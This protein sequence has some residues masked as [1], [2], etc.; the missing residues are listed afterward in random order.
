MLTLSLSLCYSCWYT[1]YFVCIAILNRCFISVHL[2]SFCD[3]TSVGV[4][5][6]FFFSFSLHQRNRIS[7]IYC[8]KRWFYLQWLT[9]VHVSQRCNLHFMDSNKNEHIERMKLKEVE[10]ESA[11]H[12]EAFEMKF[13]WQCMT[14]TVWLVVKLHD[15]EI[16]FRAQL[17]IVP[18]FRFHWFHAVFS[19]ILHPLCISPYLL[20]LS[21][22]HM[23]T[24]SKQNKR[25]QNT[26]MVHVGKDSRS[27]SGVWCGDDGEWEPKFYDLLHCIHLILFIYSCER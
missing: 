3:R 1:L 24:H 23:I 13:I 4:F 8:C 20:Y 27:D 15:I 12:I 18:W 6:F 25:Q 16:A 5:V 21:S 11:E 9:F 17:H 2:Y 14:P 10:E 26:K 7:S 22:K 19:H